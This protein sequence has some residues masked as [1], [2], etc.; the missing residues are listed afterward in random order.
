MNWKNETE[1]L[2]K[3]N[4]KHILFLCVANSVRSQMAE[5]IARTLAPSSVKISSAGSKPSRVNPL[6]IEVLSEINIDINSH[7]SKSV[8]DI[9]TKTVD[10]V[11]TLCT[12]EVCPVFLGNA[13]HL[14]WGLPDSFIDIESFR[15]IRDELFKRLS[16]LFKDSNIQKNEIIKNAVRSNYSKVAISGNSCGCSSSCCGPTQTDYKK[17]SMDLGYSKEDVDNVP[18]GANMGLGCGNPKAFASLKKGEV[19]LDLGSGGGFDCFIA[20]K[21]VGETGRVIGIDMTPEMISKARLNAMKGHYLNVEFR[22]GEIEHLPV[23]DSTIDVIIS[24]CVINL[25]TDK[26]RVF[27]EAFRVLKRG[28]RLAISDVV[29]T[30]ELPEELNQKME[31]YTGCVS[32]AST[33]LEIENILKKIGFTNIQLTPKDESR[34]FIK[35]WIQGSNV[36]DYVQSAIIEALKP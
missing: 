26:R 7:R 27:Q 36:E 13:T 9:D 6:A 30:A 32:G 28:G 4:P 5:G 18:E 14:H 8:N 23:A 19:V 3:K 33:L 17:S 1:E 35:N 31:A 12:E 34:E 29:K 11:I 10:T 22:T 16:Y 2:R 20:A 25:S 21:E 24:N 15:K